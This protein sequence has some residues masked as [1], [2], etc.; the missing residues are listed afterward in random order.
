MNVNV[1]SGTVAT[2]ITALTVTGGTLNVVEQVLAATIVGGT[3]NA[4]TVIGG[5]I[6]TD[7]SKSLLPLSSVEHL[8]LSPSSAAPLI[9]IEEVL[10][11]TIVG[12]TIN[13]RSR[14]PCALTI[15]GG[16]MNV[17]H[18]QRYSGSHYCQWTINCC[19]LSIGRHL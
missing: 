5:T 17:N 12:G 11:A 7:S 19:S 4:V 9:L 18:N 13:D 6:N 2:E 8:M 10:A 3:L 14:S 16:T 15:V 1:I